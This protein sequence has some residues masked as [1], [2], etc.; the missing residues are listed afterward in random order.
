MVMKD[1]KDMY[2]RLLIALCGDEPLGRFE[3]ALHRDKTW[4]G[5]WY[6]WQGDSIFE[7]MVNWFNSL[8]IEIKEEMEYFDDCPICQ[9]MKRGEH[10][11]EGLK[12]AFQESKDKG[13]VVGGEWFDEE[14][15][16]EL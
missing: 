10:S 6:Q 5:T 8:D 14:V 2:N 3:D 15:K 1:D 12:A 9:A 7:E 13:Y 4:L 16:N 11:L